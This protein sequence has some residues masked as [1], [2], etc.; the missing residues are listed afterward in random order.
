[1][2]DYDK[3]DADK[4]RPTKVIGTEKQNVVDINDDKVKAKIQLAQKLKDKLTLPA[5]GKK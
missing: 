4:I 1:M 3:V 2:N 5:R